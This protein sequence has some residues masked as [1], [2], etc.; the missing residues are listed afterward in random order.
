MD[1]PQARMNRGQFVGRLP[2]DIFMYD[3]GHTAADQ[4]RAILEF[5]DVLAS[6]DIRKPGHVY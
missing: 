6:V 1:F 5:E 3:G 2:A 4:F